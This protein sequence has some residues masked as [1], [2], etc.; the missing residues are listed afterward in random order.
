[1]DLHRGIG[2]AQ[3]LASASL[4]TQLAG[5]VLHFLLHLLIELSACLLLTVGIHVCVYGYGYMHG[6]TSVWELGWG[7]FQLKTEFLK[8]ICLLIYYYFYLN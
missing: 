6:M 5:L 2:Y 7:N 3:F 1:M 8:I 4:E